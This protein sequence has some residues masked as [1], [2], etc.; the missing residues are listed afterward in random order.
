MWNRPQSEAWVAT[1]ML[2]CVECI[3][4]VPPTREAEVLAGILKRSSCKG[5]E[6]RSIANMLQP[7][8]VP[9][10]FLKTFPFSCKTGIHAG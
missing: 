3:V 9:W 8:S 1:P 2:T 5:L 4:C 10:L 7:C 6:H